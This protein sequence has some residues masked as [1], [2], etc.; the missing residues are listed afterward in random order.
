MAIALALAAGK[1]REAVERGGIGGQR[2]G[3]GEK[4]FVAEDLEGWTV[5]AA[6][7]RFPPPV[8]LLQGR[9]AVGGEL[10]R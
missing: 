2:A 8:E 3:Q 6:R 9:G 10:A 4:G 1:L 7:F 5:E